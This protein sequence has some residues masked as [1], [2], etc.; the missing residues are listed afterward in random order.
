MKKYFLTA[1]VLTTVMANAQIKQGTIIYE[2]KVDVHRRMQDAQMKAMVPQFQTTKSELVFNDNISVYK[3][4]PEDNA[5]DPFN[6]GGGNVVM[7]KIGGPGDNVVLYKNY[8]N[9]KFLEQTELADK[10]YI[11]DDTIKASAWKLSDETKTVMNHA[12]KKATMKTERGSDVTAWYTEDIPS[13]VGPDTFGGLPGTIL[14][15]DVNNGEMVYTATESKK[16]ADEKELNEPSKGKH[17]TRADFDK[18]LDEM[19]GPA[20]PDGRRIV[21]RDN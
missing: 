19:F 1:L 4:L 18:K 3:A 7:I 10:A 12:C 9:Q 5:P 14:L 11:I 2:R 8:S 13:P 15:V 20:T 16:E 17:I 21:T 6:N